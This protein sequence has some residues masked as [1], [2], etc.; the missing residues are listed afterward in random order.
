MR[1]LL[2]SWRIEKFTSSS[3]RSFRTHKQE[4]ASCREWQKGIASHS[5]GS[6]TEEVGIEEHWA[7]L[8]DFHSQQPA[9][10]REVR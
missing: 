1:T 8:K 6:K 5:M 3:Q 9:L 10:H 4:M 2:E 7:V